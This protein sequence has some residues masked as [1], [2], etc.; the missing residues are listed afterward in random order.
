MPERRRAE[1]LSFALVEALRKKRQ[2][3]EMRQ[4]V[5]GYH[6]EGVDALID[7]NG[8][9]LPLK[10][11]HEGV[12]SPSLVE[13]ET[14]GGMVTATTWTFLENTVSMTR[15]VKDTGK[16]R[17]PIRRFFRRLQ[18]F[19]PPHELSASSVNLLHGRIMRAIPSHAPT[20]I[21]LPPSA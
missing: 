8:E 10:M 2:V 9:H 5:L 3:R 12:D 4:R 7:P 19:Y 14:V 6:E 11:G 1:A 13:T 21:H 20:P 17:N 15:L 18:I 16:H